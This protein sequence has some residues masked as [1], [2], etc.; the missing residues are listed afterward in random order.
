MKKASISKAIGLFPLQK[1][2]AKLAALLVCAGLAACS[3]GEINATTSLNEAQTTGAAVSEVVNPSIDAE[4][5]GD[6][7]SSTANVEQALAENSELH[8]DEQDLTWDAADVVSITLNGDSIST[9][10]EGVTVEGSRVTITAAGTHS[11]SGSLADGQIRVNTQDEEVVRLILNGVDLLLLGR[12]YPV[13]QRRDRGGRG[14][15]RRVGH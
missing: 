13:Y 7:I 6:P 11:F 9:V 10:G 2:V 14:R 1:P 5:T 15:G 12:I 4:A 8:A 3:A